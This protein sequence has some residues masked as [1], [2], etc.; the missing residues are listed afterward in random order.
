[1]NNQQVAHDLTMYIINHSSDH[2]NSMDDCSVMYPDDL[3]K[4]YKE[5]YTEILSLLNS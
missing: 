2:N 5:Q 3:V 1:M 4:F